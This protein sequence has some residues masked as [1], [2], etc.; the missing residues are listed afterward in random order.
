M[1]ELL[2]VT[3]T[4]PW[5]GCGEQ[6]GLQSP[7]ASCALKARHG[8]APRALHDP[9]AKLAQGFVVL[10]LPA[11][12]GRSACPAGTCPAHTALPCTNGFIHFAS[13]PELGQVWAPHV[14]SWGAEEKG[15]DFPSRAKAAQRGA[16]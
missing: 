8:E 5:A 9:P 12:A 4:C 16:A 3:S 1:W 7:C 10:L 11:S 13:D 6:R 14:L 15:F 2:L